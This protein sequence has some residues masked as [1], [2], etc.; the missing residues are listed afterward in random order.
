MAEHYTECYVHTIVSGKFVRSYVGEE[1][2]PLHLWRVPRMAVLRCLH[3]HFAGIL[4]M[5]YV[6]LVRRR[7]AYFVEKVA[8]KQLLDDA[9]LCKRIWLF[10]RF[11]WWPLRIHRFL[12]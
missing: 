10:D 12:T 11:R 8:R 4:L 1:C 2:D 7:S 5:L 3:D 9:L 6:P